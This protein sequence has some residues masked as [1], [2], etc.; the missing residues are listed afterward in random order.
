MD[1]V[2]EVTDSLSV[3]E[4]CDV[5]SAAVSGAFS[6]EV[7]VRGT[8]SGLK[9]HSSGTVYFDLV[10]D[11]DELGSA[12]AAVMPVALFEKDKMRVNNIL[13]KVAASGVRMTDGM[14]ILIRGAVRY[15]PRS[16]R[17]QLK[18]SLIDP[19]YTVGKMEIAKALLLAELKAEG[20]LQ[21]NKVLPLNLV[22]LNIAL[23]TSA[24]S[25]AEADF[26]NEVVSS[27][28]PFRIHLFDT[29]VQG[30]AAVGALTSSMLAISQ[31]NELI[32]VVAIVRGGGARADLVAFDH[33]DVAR[34]IARCHV[35]VIIGVG[36]DIDRSVCDEVAHTT[37]KTPTACAAH[38]VSHVDRFVGRIDN[39]SQRLAHLG[40]MHL[41]VEHNRLDS[42]AARIKAAPANLLTREAHRLDNAQ[43][44][45]RALDP[46]LALAR[47]WSI[48]R[49]T[50]GSP[51]RS[52]ADITPGTEVITILS[53][54]Q[55]RSTVSTVEV[56]QAQSDGSD[57]NGKEP[58]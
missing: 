56:D 32:D 31:S 17:V 9:R 24:N 29:R 57:N 46:A 22:P 13:K 49:T 27:G 1:T 20:L 26:V 11:S 18:M 23:V 19:S 6:T 39:A 21:S 42:I 25:A 14:E 5:V 7:W 51:V 38:I 50:D 58:A 30:D 53:D 16:G 8:I 33:G 3:R 2:R 34:A 37:T 35:P 54:G 12:T 4:L 48:T 55:I 47:G 45:A 41:K 44:R 36:H 40:Q 52:A 10:D 43:V 15:Y 28:F